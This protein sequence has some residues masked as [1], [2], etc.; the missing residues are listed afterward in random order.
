MKRGLSININFN[1]RFTYTFIVAI[2]VVIAAVSVFAYGTSNP[3][4]FGHSAGEIGLSG[5]VMFFN[6]I[7]CPTGWTEFTDARGRSLVGL[8]SGGTLDLKVGTALSNGEDRHVGSHQ[9][10]YVVTLQEVDV[11][12]DGTGIGVLAGTALSPETHTSTT[13]TQGQVG[14]TNAPYVQLLACQKD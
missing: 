4:V 13:S 7:T 12:N 9:H 6:S 1:N 2:V 10:T 8:N 11:N 5:A 3:V 14:G